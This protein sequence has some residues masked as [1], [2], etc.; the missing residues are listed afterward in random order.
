MVRT[1]ENSGCCSVVHLNARMYFSRYSFFTVSFLCEAEQK[2]EQCSYTEQ[3]L[4]CQ[5]QRP[6]Q[7]NIQL[8]ESFPLVSPRMAGLPG[9]QGY[10]TVQ[11]AVYI[12]ILT[13]YHKTSWR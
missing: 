11:T 4:P 9:L 1:R 2:E 13:E 12:S 10:A 5:Q 3:N 8:T 6:E 7:F